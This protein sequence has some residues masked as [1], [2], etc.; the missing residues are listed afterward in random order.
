VDGVWVRFGILTGGGSVSAESVLT[1]AAGRAGV[2]LTLGA[3]GAQTV[4]A[5]VASLTGSALFTATSVA[6]TGTTKS[7]ANAAGG[8]WSTGTNWSPAGAPGPLDTA[9]ITLAGTYTVTLDASPTIAALTVGGA[10]GVQTLSATARILTVNGGS[11]IGANGRVTFSGGTFVGPAA[12]ITNAGVLQIF[13]AIVNDGIVNTGTVQLRASS[14]LVGNITNNAGGTVLVEA[15]NGVNATATLSGSVTNRGT[16]V[17]THVGTGAGTEAATLTQTA[18]ALVN[19]VGGVVRAEAGGS[20]GPRVLSVALDN[21]GLLEVNQTLVMNRA[22]AV[23]VNSG[24]VMLG[25]G[26]LVVTQSGTN[27]SWT[28]TGLLTVPA[29]RTLGV[30]GG[31]FTA[32]G[33]TLAGAGTVSLTGV[34]WN[35]GTGYVV[36][37]MTVVFVGGAMTGSGPLTV[38]GPTSLV[39]VAVGVAV[40][41]ESVLSLNGTTAVTGAASNTAGATLIIEAGGPAVTLSGGLTNSGHVSIAPGATLAVTGSFT[42]AQSGA[43][44][45]HGVLNVSGATIAA[46]DGA[47]NPGT[48]P[49]ILGITG[50]LPQGATSVMTFEVNGPT[51][52][53]DLDRLNVSGMASLA[54]T[55]SLS[56]GT[57]AHAARARRL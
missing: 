9:Q 11:T 38:R 1:D 19:E 23:H 3:A 47:V 4:E 10:T 52:G 18:A 39:D 15:T 44:D 6:V 17:L 32:G 26:D 16:V 43:L 42:H 55:L 49:G 13:G 57:A 37:G 51:A 35:I 36:N 20:A 50:P 14:S 56:L 29:G 41:N 27:P 33:A 54:G 22:S 28:N 45:G 53:V 8:N 31:T 46:F 30:S 12:T 21:R 24:S 5:T 2:T 34:S 48:S 40:S 7:W 25:G